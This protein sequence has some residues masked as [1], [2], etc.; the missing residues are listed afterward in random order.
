MSKV[1]VGLTLALALGQSASALADSAA[2]KFQEIYDLLRTNLTGVSETELNRAA[3]QGLIEQLRPKVEVTGTHSTQQDAIATKS[4]GSF[5]ASIF[6]NSYGYFRVG[7]MAPDS[8]QKLKESFQKFSST[9]RL[10]G[11]VL[12]L[13]Y[14]DGQDYKAA[15]MLADCFFSRE[16]ALIDW[17]EGLQRATAKTN[18]LQLPL[19]VLINGK[20]SGA[21]EA[22][23][24]ILRQGQVGLIIG[25]NSAGNAAIGREFTLS[26]GD[27][28]RVATTPIKFADGKAFPTSGLKPDIYVDVDPA[29]ELVW[30]DDSFKVPAKP[31]AK[32]M[33]TG[34]NETALASTNRSSRRRLN[35][36]ELVRMLKEG[37]NP[38]NEVAS[39]AREMERAKGLVS[40]PVLARALDLLKGLTVVQQFR[41][42]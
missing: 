7:Q 20:T 30:F 17:G 6:E 42:S 38:E 29:D 37:I 21:A 34:T 23:A 4:V 2:P 33:S 25:T 32:I 28:L 19:A 9:N 31:L 5:R 3:V 26:T 27:R 14:A 11:I 12:D 18:A 41:S 8:G 15:A 35:E 40:D 16:E 10:K 39:G 24:G 13:R 1:I 36:A 22:V